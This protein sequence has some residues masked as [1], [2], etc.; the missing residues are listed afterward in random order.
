MRFL[1]FAALP[2]LLV[3]CAPQKPAVSGKQLTI[4]RIFAS[5][6]LSGPTPRLL[7]LSPDGRYATLL[8]SRPEDRERFDLWAMDT[9]TGQMRMLVDSTKLGGGEI[10]EAEKM[11]RERARV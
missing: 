9:S 2:L 6:D 7:K 10:S 1:A 3:A 4:D 5:P 11:R 8:K